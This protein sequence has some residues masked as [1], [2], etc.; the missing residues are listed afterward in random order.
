MDGLGGFF[1]SA[2]CKTSMSAG[3]SGM[4]VEV[5]EEMRRSERISWKRRGKY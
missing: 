1:I 2:D 5:A 4:Y 3:A